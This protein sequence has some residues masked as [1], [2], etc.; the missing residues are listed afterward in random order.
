MR[1]FIYCWREWT[2]LAVMTAALTAS[3]VWFDV[4][5]SAGESADPMKTARTAIMAD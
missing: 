5:G 2:V 4:V 3:L 1:D